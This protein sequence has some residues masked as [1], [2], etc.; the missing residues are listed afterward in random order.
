[1]GR[2][3]TGLGGSVIG[4]SRGEGEDDF[5]LNSST[6]K[7]SWDL[8]YFG[9]SDDD[10]TEDEDFIPVSKKRKEPECAIKKELEPQPQPIVKVITPD[11]LTV[12]KRKVEVSIKQPTTK[13][14]GLMLL[15]NKFIEFC[16]NCNAAKL[17]SN[18]TEIETYRDYEKT[19]ALVAIKRNDFKNDP[20][21]CI[22]Q[23]INQWGWSYD[24]FTEKEQQCLFKFCATIF[25]F[26]ETE[27]LNKVDQ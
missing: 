3:N 25:R 1:M 8:K 15:V 23:F 19:I 20:T 10:S 16:L 11:F 2:T 13:K 24:H 17:A 18:T 14:E 6:K 12:K 22:R 27:I 21:T 26:A 9:E 5:T 4:I 7:V